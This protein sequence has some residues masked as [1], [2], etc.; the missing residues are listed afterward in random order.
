M[1]EK[2][3]RV[4]LIGDGEA[5]NATETEAPPPTTIPTADSLHVL[6]KQAIHAQ[7]HA[8]LVECLSTTD[9]KVITNSTALLNPS[10]V[11]MLLKSLLSLIE[12]RGSL[13]IHAIPWLR[14]LL[15]QHASC[16]ASQESSFLILNSFCQ[17]IDARISTYQ[18]A[19]QLSASLDCL[20]AKI[21][22]AEESSS[23]VVIYEDNDSDEEEEY[24][25]TM[26]IDE[27]SDGLGDVI[28]S[29][30]NS[31]GSDIMSD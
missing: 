16:I 15:L 30:H 26:E 7:D 19:L 2:L 4:E 8:L 22:E 12:S 18:T 24:D 1:A 11:L 20:C 5:K 21:P 14:S 17:L 29:A 10:D 25:E 27:E 31:D 13:L 9:G 23:P 6:L 28:D 3:A